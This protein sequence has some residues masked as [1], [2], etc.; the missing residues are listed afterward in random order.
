MVHRRAAVKLLVVDD[1]AVVREGVRR[2]L[3]QVPEIA[4]VETSSAHEAGVLFRNERPDVVLLDLNLP[5]ESGLTLLRRLLVEDKSARILIFSMHE[6]VLYVARALE[7]GARGYVSKSAPAAELMA[8]IQK[9][10]A[11]GRYI[12]QEIAADLLVNQIRSD[13]PFNRLTAREADIMRQLGEGKT[14]AAIANALGVSYKTVA[15]SCTIIKSKL[16]A[17]RVADLIRLAIELRDC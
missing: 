7:I 4:V 9:V 11:G 17:E 14:L 5:N 2:L 10:A 1:H 8:A 13:V 6:E 15:N 3:A 16:G 12:E